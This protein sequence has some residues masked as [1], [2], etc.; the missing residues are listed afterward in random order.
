MH[1]L[2]YPFV[3]N[4]FFVTNSLVWFQFG[5]WTFWRHSITKTFS[6]TA[7]VVSTFKL[8]SFK[9]TIVAAARTLFKMLEIIQS[10]LFYKIELSIVKFKSSRK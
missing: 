4:E 10:I 8:T 3:A 9:G 1:F 7:V 5:H 2:N 6:S